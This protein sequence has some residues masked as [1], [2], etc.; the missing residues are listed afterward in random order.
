MIFFKNDGYRLLSNPNF[1]E[2]KRTYSD[3]WK[4]ESFPEKQWKRVEQQLK[5]I[6]GV[7]EFKSI[8][9]LIKASRLINPS[10]LEIGCSSGYLSRVLPKVKYEGTDYSKAFIEFA[11]LKFPKIKFT[12]N[13]ATDLKYKDN[14]FDIV[15]S[16]SCLLH[17][18]NHKKAIAEASRVAKKFVIF[19]RTP[20]LHVTQTSYLTKSAY[21]HKMMDI[22]FNEEDLIDQF[23][24]NN[25]AVVKSI[26]LGLGKVSV[27]EEKMA[28]KSYL[29][30][31][32]S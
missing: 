7:P 30:K 6:N 18:I 2:L 12:V 16:G 20:I 5:H 29:C 23:Y 19:H 22:F 24:K 11:K 10:V 8:R 4:D 26:T 15:I 31:K 21:G 1:R 28:M 27:F 13:D 32:V 3:V 25:L 14:M 9:D 17:I